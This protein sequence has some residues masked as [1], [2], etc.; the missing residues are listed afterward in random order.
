MLAK[1][2]YKMAN[3]PSTYQQVALSVT[4]ITQRLIFTQKYQWMQPRPSHFCT[5]PLSNND[6][7]WRSGCKWSRYENSLEKLSWK[8]L[9]HRV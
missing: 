7:K 8:V 5:L 1:V 2:L 6:K 9:E 4:V 3:V